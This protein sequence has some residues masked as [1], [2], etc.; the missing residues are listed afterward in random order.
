MQV[1]AMKPT[2]KAPGTKR[3][4]LKYDRLLSISLQAC[5]QI[6]L[7]P[8]PR[9]RGSTRLAATG[10]RRCTPP[11]RRATRRWQG[12]TLVHV[13]AR[14]QPSLSMK[15]YET[16]ICIHR[17]RSRQVEKWTSVSP[18]AA[19]RAL[20]AAGA[21]VKKPRNDGRQGLI[22]VHV[23]AQLEPVLTQNAS[24]TSEHLL[25]TPSTT[26]QCTPY[27]TGGA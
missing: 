18:E 26:P 7:A 2:V 17:E 24:Y 4:K 3:L 15:L 19:V 6:Q 13:L 1:A 8:L 27:P 10:R 9:G 23:S 22:R 11:R 21:D 12:L 5:F 16:T 25:H 14:P 20:V